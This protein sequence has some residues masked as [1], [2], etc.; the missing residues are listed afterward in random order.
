MNKSVFLLAIFFLSA[1]QLKSGLHFNDL[2]AQKITPPFDSE[3]EVAIP[4]GGRTYV[5]SALRQIF[6]MNT[7]DSDYGIIQ[8]NIF[9]RSDFGDSCDHYDAGWMASTGTTGTVTYS[10]EF[11][12]ATCKNGIN[13]TL[14]ALNNPMRFAWTTRVCENLILNSNGARLTQLMQ[15]L[16]SGWTVSTAHQTEFTPTAESVTKAYQKFYRLDEPKP[17]VLD[18]LLKLGVPQ[19]KSNLDRWKLIWLT[20]CISPEWQM[21]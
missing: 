21:I 2:A 18:K 19:N 6:Q 14:P 8:S 9:E 10:K 3:Y 5:D 1:C 11:P 12:R 4:I 20:I 13:P 16:H 17:D 7:T 15:Y